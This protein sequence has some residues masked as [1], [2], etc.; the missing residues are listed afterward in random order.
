MAALDRARHSQH[1]R[2]A[3]GPLRESTRRT[4][5][6]DPVRAVPAVEVR[7]RHQL[8]PLQPASVPAQP[9]TCAVLRD[10]KE[11]TGD[12]DSQT[13]QRRAKH[14]AAEVVVAV[15]ETAQ[16]HVDFFVAVVLAPL[17]L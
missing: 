2:F 12:E 14:Q 11:K 4:R 3:R 8:R 5:E 15:D 1:V 6:A 7:D 9:R 16:G 13:D 17:G 10:R